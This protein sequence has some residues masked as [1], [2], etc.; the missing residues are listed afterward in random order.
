MPGKKN[1]FNFFDCTQIMI[2]ILIYLLIFLKKWFITYNLPFQ[3]K[4]SG[5][6]VFLQI[7]LFFYEWNE[8][9]RKK[10]LGN[11]LKLDVLMKKGYVDKMVARSCSLREKRKNFLKRKGLNYLKEQLFFLRKKRSSCLKEQL[12]PGSKFSNVWPESSRSK[13]CP[14]KT[15]FMPLESFQNIDI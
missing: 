3:P 12:P 4:G 11:F 14:N 9:G 10:L 15:F 8:W 6:N 5:F 7:F 13:L 1:I 2:I